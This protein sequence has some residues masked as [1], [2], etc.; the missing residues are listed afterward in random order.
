MTSLLVVFY[1]YCT[2]R[3]AGKM[4]LVLQEKPA[5]YI[6]FDRYL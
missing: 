4:E 2:R 5:L 6:G 1:I 3:L